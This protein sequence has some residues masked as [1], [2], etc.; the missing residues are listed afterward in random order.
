MVTS[1]CRSLLVV[2]LITAKLSVPTYPLDRL[3]GDRVL[4]EA[5]DGPIMICPCM[6]LRMTRSARRVTRATAPSSPVGAPA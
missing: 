3:V 6:G 2:T 1:T 5:D 4:F